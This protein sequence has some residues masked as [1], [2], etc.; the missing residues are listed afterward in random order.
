MSVTVQAA[1]QMQADQD[2]LAAALMNLLDNS[3]VARRVRCCLGQRARNGRRRSIAIAGCPGSAV[4][5]R[6]HRSWADACGSGCTWTWRT[7][8]AVAIGGGLRGGDLPWR[9]TIGFTRCR[10]CSGPVARSLPGSPS[11]QTST[12]S[13]LTNRRPSIESFSRTRSVVGALRACVARC[14]LE[15][16]E[17][18]PYGACASAQRLVGRGW[19]L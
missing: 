9:T 14:T 7:P 2:L 5:R 17:A 8:P 13:P 19:S 1:A 16:K 10:C 12:A 11:G 4:V 6:S 18:G 3:H 15:R